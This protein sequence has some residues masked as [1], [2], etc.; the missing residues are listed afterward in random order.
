VTEDRFLFL[1]E[2]KAYKTPNWLLP[3]CFQNHGNFVISLSNVTRWLGQQAEALGVEIF[4]ASR[5]PK[6]CTTRT[7]RSRAWPPA[8]WAS[9]RKAN[10]PVTSSWAW[11][12]TPNTPSS[13]KVR[14]HLGKQLIAKYKLD[15]GR[16]PQTYAIG[17]KELW[18][19]KPEV[20]QPGLVVHTAGWP[21]T[22]TPTAA[23]SCITWRTTRWPSVRGGP[24]YQNPYLSPFEE[25]QRYK[26]HPRS[27]SSSK[28]AS[29]SPMAPA[30]SPPAACNRC[31][32]WSSRA[33]R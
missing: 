28:A 3:T 27:A 4:P 17:I 33:A 16:D 9:T 13:P 26:T 30:R 10:R 12:C 22:T 7:A 2:S 5:Q 19:V 20:H 1:S 29:A 18:E 6:C 15:A 24:G 21:L 32:S 8:T 23:P 25:F 31:P 14:G 11:S